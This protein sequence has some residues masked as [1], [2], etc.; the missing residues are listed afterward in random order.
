MNNINAKH[1]SV[2]DFVKSIASELP[3]NSDVRPR[4]RR[5]G[6]RVVIAA[7]IVLCVMAVIGGFGAMKIS[8]A[9]RMNFSKTVRAVAICEGVGPNTI[10]AQFRRHYG[11]PSISEMNKITYYRGLNRL[12][13]RMCDE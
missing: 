11:Y 8:A 4:H 9:Q 5:A 6:R 7:M 13:Q 3:A 2:E 12:K 1:V 10:H